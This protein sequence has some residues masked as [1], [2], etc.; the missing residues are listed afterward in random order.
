ML[1]HE[2]IP[3]LTI[4]MNLVKAIMMV[5]AQWVRFMLHHLVRIATL[6]PHF[7]AL[8]DTPANDGSFLACYAVAAV[9][10]WHVVAGLPLESTLSTMLWSLV[11]MLMTS[12]RKQNSDSLFCTLM[13]A[14]TITD[15]LAAGAMCSGLVDQP[16]HVLF[17]VLECV[18]VMCC[19]VRFQQ[20]P[21][22]VRRAGYKRYV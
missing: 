10:R 9:L 21:T 18:L 12:V 4:S 19:F 15:L 14:S 5:I 13:G 20:E 11:P 7:S 1:Q 16:N 3:Q 2:N 22:D 17:L 8:A 6:R